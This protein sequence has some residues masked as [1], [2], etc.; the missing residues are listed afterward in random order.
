M[1]VRKGLLREETFKLIAKAQGMIGKQ[2][3]EGL[4]CVKARGKGNGKVRLTVGNLAQQN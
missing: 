1:L 3:R 2:R 4:A